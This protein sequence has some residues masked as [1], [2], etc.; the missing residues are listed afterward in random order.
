MQK[1][2]QSPTKVDPQLVREI[3]LEV[4]ARQ[5]NPNISASDAIQFIFD[6]YKELMSTLDSKRKGN[7]VPA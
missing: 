6:E 7:K 1:K 2:Q 3:K 4:I 5:S